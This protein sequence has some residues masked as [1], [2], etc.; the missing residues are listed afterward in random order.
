MG[1]AREEIRRRSS[2]VNV[3]LYHPSVYIFFFFSTFPRWK[4]YFFFFFF[5]TSIVC[6]VSISGA[7]DFYRMLKIQ[8]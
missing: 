1:G 3:N 8:L 4:M 5:V 2:C 7:K 6:D